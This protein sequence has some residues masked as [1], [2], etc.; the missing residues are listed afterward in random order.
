MSDSRSWRERFFPLFQRCALIFSSHRRTS[1]GHHVAC[2]SNLSKKTKH[3]DECAI[4]LCICAVTLIASQMFGLKSR[5]ADFVGSQTAGTKFADCECAVMWNVRGCKAHGS[6]LR[7]QTVQPRGYCQVAWCTG[8][9]SD[10][11]GKGTK[12]QWSRTFCR[13]TLGDRFTREPKAHASTAMN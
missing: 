6:C 8:E 3:V 7:L 4:R 9:E 12:H 2:V 11:I 5:H 1:I 13:H 10:A